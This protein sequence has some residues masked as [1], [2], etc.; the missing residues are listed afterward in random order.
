[1]LAGYGIAFMLLKKHFFKNKFIN[2]NK[3]EFKKVLLVNDDKNTEV[4]NPTVEGALV[5]GLVLDNIRDTKITKA[6][7]LSDAGIV[8]GFRDKF[9]KIEEYGIDM[10]FC[11]YDEAIAFSGKET[12]EEAINFFKNSSYM[13][14]IT[15]GSKGSIVIKDGEAIVSPA[16]EINP[17]DTNGAG[18]MFAGAFMHAMLNGKGLHEC[19][20]FA[21]LAASKIV[22]TF[23]PR[24]KKEEYQNLI[25]NL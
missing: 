15:V 2:S 7:S 19:G 14:A 9:E 25:E 22:Q 1:M 5:E 16:V 3:V 12:L 23:G 17:I 13:I 21:N 24:L 20:A 11:N 10:I 4:G 6:L 18:D 8:M